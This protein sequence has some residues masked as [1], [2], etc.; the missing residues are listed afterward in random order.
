MHIQRESSQVHAITAY[1]ETGLTIDHVDYHKSLIISAETIIPDWSVSAL[2]DLN[3]H[4][5]APLVALHPEVIIIGYTDTLTHPPIAL[6]L[7]LSQQG[8]GIEFMRLGA[9]CR[10]FNVLL[11]ENRRVVGGFIFP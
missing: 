1:D 7:W 4:Q 8:I 6:M 5:L 10:T 9:A 11:S 2:S 3:K